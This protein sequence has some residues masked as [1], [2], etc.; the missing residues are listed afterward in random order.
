MRV[1]AEETGLSRSSGHAPETTVWA[2]LAS[3]GQP[4]GPGSHPSPAKPSHRPYPR[5]TSGLKPF[6]ASTADGSPATDSQ[7]PTML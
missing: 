1:Y 6:A 2:G 7:L 3:M 4:R 5:L